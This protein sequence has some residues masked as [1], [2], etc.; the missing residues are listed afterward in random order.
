M[1]ALRIRALTAA[2]A[3]ALLSAVPLA[4]VAT[5]QEAPPPG[6]HKTEIPHA[7]EE[8][9]K[10]L[11]GGGK[12]EE[13]HD[14]PSPILPEP[15]EIIWGSISFLALLFLM[16]KF[17]YPVM[18]K[19]MDAR[20]EKIRGDLDDADRVKTE[21]ATLLEE[22]KGQ[23]ADA[24]N[25]SSRIIEE[26]R[27]TADQLRRDLM[28]RAEAEVAEL[29]QR[30]RDDIAAAQERAMTDL[31]ARVGTM[32]IDLAEKVV[33]ANLD[34]DANLRLIDSYITQVGSSS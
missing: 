16:S 2:T 25:E 11:E 22:Y 34:R 30:T 14:A 31:Q 26:A 3:L 8:C 32:A 17:A 1:P 15:K 28:Q 18:K 6:E 12:P 5:A 29:R 33:E 19:T 21:A 23:L 7:S 27:Q 20:S 4:G 24:R 9:I 13:C 10:L